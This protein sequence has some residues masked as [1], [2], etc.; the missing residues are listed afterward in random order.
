MYDSYFCS[1]Y[2]DTFSYNNDIDCLSDDY[3]TDIVVCIIIS[4]FSLKYYI[5]FFQNNSDSIVVD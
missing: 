4:I 3:N 2:L 1:L 5:K